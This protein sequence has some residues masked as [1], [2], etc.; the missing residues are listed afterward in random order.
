MYKK[1][2]SNIKEMLGV[3]S[4]LATLGFAVFGI[5]SLQEYITVYG[6]IFIFVIII[7]MYKYA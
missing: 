7:G 6:S 4:A 1:I 3:T 2:K 5:F